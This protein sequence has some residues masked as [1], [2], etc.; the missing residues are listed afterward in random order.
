MDMNVFAKRLKDTRQNL[1]M[2]MADLAEKTELT[3]SAISSYEK[4]GGKVPSLA[5]AQKIASVLG[6]SLDW[7]SG[8]DDISLNE[9][10]PKEV[11]AENVIKAIDVLRKHTP[12]YV[13]YESK[14]ND[15]FYN[16]IIGINNS[17]LPSYLSEME[18]INKAIE[19][20]EMSLPLQSMVKNEIKKKY[21]EAIAEEIKDGIIRDD[22]GFRL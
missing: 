1:D 18:S 3:T 16:F 7:L 21:I 12:F 2:S 6:V 11:I 5:N 8:A 14:V 19:I 20:S 4:A 22:D 10:A 15:Q 13:I 9:N 17:Q